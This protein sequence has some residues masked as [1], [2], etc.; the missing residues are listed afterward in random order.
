[1]KTASTIID[2]AANANLRIRSVEL[3]GSE[4]EKAELEFK[5]AQRRLKCEREF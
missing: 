5:T 4:G 2:L 3:I 1:M